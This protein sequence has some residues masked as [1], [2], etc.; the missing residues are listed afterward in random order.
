[1][2]FFNSSKSFIINSGDIRFLGTEVLSNLRTS[3]ANREIVKFVA[4]MANDA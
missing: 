2:I 3:N 4:V 1:V